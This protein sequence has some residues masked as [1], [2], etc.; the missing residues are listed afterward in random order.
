MLMIF[1]HFIDGLSV[2]KYDKLTV[3]AVLTCYLCFNRK[4]RNRASQ[5]QKLVR[6]QKY[7]I[8]ND[9]AQEYHD[10]L[11]QTIKEMKEIRVT[12]GVHITLDF[13]NDMKHDVIA[14][15]VIQFIIGNCKGNDLLYG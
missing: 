1:Y 10:M 8:R 7:Y 5:D 13:G 2:D 12:G 11:S 3:E 9:R 6:D 15:P 4:D 14:I